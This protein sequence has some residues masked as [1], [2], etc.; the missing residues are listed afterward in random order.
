M[1]GIT[2]A[3]SVSRVV[4]HHGARLWHTTFTLSGWETGRTPTRHRFH[5]Q[6]GQLR[7]QRLRAFD[8]SP[9]DASH[10][11]WAAAVALASH[12]DAVIRGDEGEIYDLQTGEIV[13]V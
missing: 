6:I 4:R 1:P 11:V 5:W 8:C 13:Y 12:L 2:G 10:P 7:S 9:R 3:G